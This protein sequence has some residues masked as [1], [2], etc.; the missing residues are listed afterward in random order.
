MRKNF[1]PKAALRS[2]GA[3]TAGR[4]QDYFEQDNAMIIRPILVRLKC[5]A[6]GE[7]QTV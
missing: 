4:R 1:R 2:A 7:P 6:V 3:M 5:W